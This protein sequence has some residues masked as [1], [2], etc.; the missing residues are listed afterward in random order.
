[1]FQLHGLNDDDKIA[2]L[3]GRAHSRGLVL[4]DEVAGY[5]LRHCHRDLTALLEL[6]ERLDRASLAGQRRLTVPFVKD[7]L[8]AENRD[9]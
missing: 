8:E 1:M 6:L 7:V 4:P 5:L 2:V 9:E 3:R